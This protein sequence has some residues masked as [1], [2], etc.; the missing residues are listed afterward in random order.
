MVAGRAQWL[1]GLASFKVGESRRPL[2]L[3]AQWLGGLVPLCP[4]RLESRGVVASIPLLS[5]RL[6][7][8]KI[9]QHFF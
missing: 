9:L 3:V 1:G 5:L 2:R 8:I 7:T 6:E 4:L